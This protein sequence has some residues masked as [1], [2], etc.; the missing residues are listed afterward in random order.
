MELHLYNIRNNSKRVEVLVL[1]LA[2]ALEYP[3]I[4]SYIILLVSLEYLHGKSEF[5]LL[6]S[7][8]YLSVKS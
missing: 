5:I 8:L 1:L 6:V 2:W 7:E 4:K 3:F